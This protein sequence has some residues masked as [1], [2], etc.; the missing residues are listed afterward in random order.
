MALVRAEADALQRRCAAMAISVP[1]IPLE[2][3]GAYRRRCGR[4]AAVA[5]AHA[6]PWSQCVVEAAYRRIVAL[7]AEAPEARTWL[8]AAFR[9]WD[10]AWLA[11]RRVAAGSDSVHSGLI[12]AR[13]APGRASPRFEEG[14]MEACREAGIHFAP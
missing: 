7:R 13:V 1:R 9:T 14:T 11:G 6:R 8:G 10:A 12:R 4:I 3:V 5:L 2:E